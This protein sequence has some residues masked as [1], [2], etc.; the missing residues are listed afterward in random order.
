M[1]AFYEGRL[2]QMETVLQERESEREQLAEA[3]SHAITSDQSNKKDLEDKLR[4]K[5]EHIASLKTKR[6]QLSLL[7]VVIVF[8]K[9]TMSD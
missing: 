1:R 3:L 6:K 8:N 7:S 9:L 2:K 4:R 5:D